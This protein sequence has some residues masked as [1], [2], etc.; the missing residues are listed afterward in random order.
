MGAT[1]SKAS[2]SDQSEF[3]LFAGRGLHLPESQTESDSI[4][5]PSV[6]VVPFGGQS[7]IARI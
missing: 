6:D 5:V 1:G 2:L 7:G 4:T 3:V